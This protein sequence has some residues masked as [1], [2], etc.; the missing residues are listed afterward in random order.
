[1]KEIILKGGKS[2]LI[3]DLDVDS[4]LP[5]RWVYRQGGYASTRINGRAVHLHRFILNAPEDKEVDH[6]NGNGLDNRRLNLRLCSHAE[7]MQNRKTHKN[8]TS[9]HKGIWLDRRCGKWVATIQCDGERKR[10]GSS[11]DKKELIVLRQKAEKELYK[12]FQRIE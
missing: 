10:L 11:F 9:G 3:D 1:M 8:N 12:D 5:F 7:N 4:I 6:K 2:A